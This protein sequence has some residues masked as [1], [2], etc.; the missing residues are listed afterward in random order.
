V[1]SPNPESHSFK[2]AAAVPSSV[3]FCKEFG[4]E[5]SFRRY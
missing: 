1:K 4:G 2:K 5:F 3:Q